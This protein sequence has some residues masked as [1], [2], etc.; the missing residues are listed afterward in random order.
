MTDQ[1]IFSESSATPSPER[2]L[3][4]TTDRLLAHLEGGALE[5]SFGPRGLTV[6]QAAG[7]PL[8][9]DQMLIVKMRPEAAVIPATA[10]SFGVTATLANWETPVASSGLRL[11]SI[12]ERGGYVRRA[13]SLTRRPLSDVARAASTARPVMTAVLSAFMEPEAESKTLPDPNQGTT[14]L[15]L[16]SP[17]R[18]EQLRKAFAED[19]LVEFVARVPVRYHCARKR[20]PRPVS[21]ALR[22]AMANPPTAELWNLQKIEWARARALGS[23]DDAAS[24]KVAV[25]DTGVDPDHFDLRGRISAY[26]YVYPNSGVTAGVRDYVGHGTHVSGTIGASINNRIGINGIC[27]CQ[28]SVYKIFSD[29]TI[30]FPQLGYYAYVVDPIMYRQALASCLDDEVDV[31]NLSIGGGGEPDPRERQLF[32]ELIA[33]GTTIVAAMGNERQEGSPISYPAALPD[34]IAVGAT[35]IDDSVANFSNRG[36]HIT[37]SAPGVGIWSTLPTYD[38]QAGFRAVRSPNGNVVRGQA[39]KREREYAA[40]D[41]TSMATPHV[42]AAVALFLANKGKHSPQ[43]VKNALQT[44]ADKTPQMAGNF[45]P[46]YG[47]GRLN[48]LKLLS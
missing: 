44:S 21:A 43:D 3:S 15:E 12:L 26:N 42:T 36:P 2:E 48:L 10:A 25:C 5:P 16:E 46:D 13:V 45:D 20:A 38:G 31:I 8:Y 9:H 17:G 23:F 24:I 35:K 28:L 7:R 34:V 30:F 47:A 41:G 11:L 14:I 1:L 37:L 4:L 6:S 29:E 22:R 27:S 39:I 32:S 33:R 19:P 40:W 18:A